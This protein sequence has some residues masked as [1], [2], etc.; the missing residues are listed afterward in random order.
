MRLQYNSVKSSWLRQFLYCSNFI[1]VECLDHEA[2]SCRL[3]YTKKLG[4]V[5]FCEGHQSVNDK[6]NIHYFLENN[7]IAS[8]IQMVVNIVHVTI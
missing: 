6:T 5:P 7:F 4:E 8:I 2:K 3:P 1:C